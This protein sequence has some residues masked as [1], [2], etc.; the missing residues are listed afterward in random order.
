MKDLKAL[1]LSWRAEI[2]AELEEATKALPPLQAASKAAT[3]AADEAASAYREL[4]Q[5]LGKALSVTGFLGTQYQYLEGPIGIRANG[6]AMEVDQAKSQRA[7]ALADL[8]LARAKVTSLQRS[9][10]QIDRVI[11]PAAETQEA[12]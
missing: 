2:A 3:A 1:I 5:L 8:E 4:Q 11:P 6:V 10:A 12:A 9:L 7:R